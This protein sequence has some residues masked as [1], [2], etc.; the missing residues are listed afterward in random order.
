M[1]NYISNYKIL[2]T[3]E[4][5]NASSGKTI[6][7][8]KMKNG[9]LQVTLYDFR[10]NHKKFL[11]HRLVALQHIPNPNNLSQ[12]N[13]K[14]MD[15]ENN[16]VSN[17]EWCDA[18]YNLNHARKNGESIYTEKRN[19]KISLAK[20]GISRSEETKQKLSKYW[21]EKLTD[22]EKTAL[23]HRLHKHKPSKACPLCLSNN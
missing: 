6:K 9:Y 10:G 17:L 21:R 2:K 13:H 14:D 1:D 20:R 15:K 4:I 23:A 19:R 11:V 5:K 8:Y 18:K 3:G 7:P 22:E 16:D 12:I